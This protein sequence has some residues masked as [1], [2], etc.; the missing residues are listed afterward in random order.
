MAAEGRADAIDGGGGVAKSRTS[1]HHP[2]RHM[3]PS[4]AKIF[5]GV[6]THAE[7]A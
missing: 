5:C 6:I 2:E 3:V 7:V 1:N 4:P